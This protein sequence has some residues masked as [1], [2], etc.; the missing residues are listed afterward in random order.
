MLYHGM[1]RPQV[2]DEGTTSNMAVQVKSD[3]NSYGCKDVYFSSVQQ[4]KTLQLF[5][6][7]RNSC[8]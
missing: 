4:M 6:P 1:G 2:A 5:P 8:S 7:E 3:Y